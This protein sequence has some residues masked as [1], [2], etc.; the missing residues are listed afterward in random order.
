[1]ITENDRKKIMELIEPEKITLKYET[2]AGG[3]TTLLDLMRLDRILFD[4]VEAGKESANTA[5]D[6][7]PHTVGEIY[8]NGMVLCKS[9]NQIMNTETDKE[10]ARRIILEIVRDCY[11]VVGQYQSMPIKWFADYSMQWLDGRK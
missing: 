4:L 7:C 1:M 10:I 2:G 9:C 3:F 6:E 11:K 8:Q 5:E